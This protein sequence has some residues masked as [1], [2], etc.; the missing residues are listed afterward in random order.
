M[1]KLGCICGH[2]IV[3]QTDNIIYK[4]HFVRDQDKEAIGEQTTDIEAFIEAV[5]KGQRDKWLNNYFGSDIY[6][7]LTDATVV[8]DIISRY[9]VKFESEMFV[10]QNCGRIKI[11]KGNEN[12]FVSFLPEDNQWL[13][14]FKGLSRT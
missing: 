11:Q 1:S 8:N 5:R 12:K 10:C 14:I 7:T 4:A 13:G 2:T 9:N 6:K 3:D